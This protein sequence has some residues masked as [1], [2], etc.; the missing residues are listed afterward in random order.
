[1]ETVIPKLFEER[2]KTWDR[3]PV[4]PEMTA[5][6]KPNNRPPNAAT[7]VAF[8]KTEFNVMP[9]PSVRCWLRFL[10]QSLFQVLME[11][12]SRQ[13]SSNPGWLPVGSPP[14]L[15]RDLRSR[16]FPVVTIRCPIHVER[17]R[18]KHRPRQPYPPLEL[19]NRAPQCIARSSE[20]STPA[21]PG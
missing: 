12:P 3:K 18:Q 19:D 7:P 5:V 11:E 6:S 1:M 13:P 2:L 10:F 14:A 16:Q 17:Q 8:N 9:S 21:S 20:P 15:P 4:V